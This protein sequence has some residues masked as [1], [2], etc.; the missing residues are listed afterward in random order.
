MLLF[1]YREY[2]FMTFANH[3]LFILYTK[4]SLHAAF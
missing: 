4:F 3:F 2:G 1:V